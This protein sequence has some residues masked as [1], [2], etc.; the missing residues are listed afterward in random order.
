MKP[1]APSPRA[2]FTVVSVRPHEATVDARTRAQRDLAKLRA[3]LVEK[4]AADPV[5]TAVPRPTP[6]PL[7]RVGRVWALRS[8]RTPGRPRA[9]CS[10]TRSPSRLP[11]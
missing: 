11:A 6:D 3:L 5:T 10:R 8:P 9:G 4:L 7:P 1:G 2:R